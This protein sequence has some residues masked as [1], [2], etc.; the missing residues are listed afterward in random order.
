MKRIVWVILTLPVVLTLLW[1]Q[2][3]PDGFALD[4][5]WP[6]RSAMV[7]YSGVLVMAAMSVAL[8]LAARPALGERLCGGLDKCYRLHKWLGISALL[9]ATLHWL[10][11]QGPKWA[12]GL[13]W[14]ERPAR[15][16]AGQA[17]E[18]LA[19][20]LQGQ[21]GIAESLGEWA[22]YACVL[23]IVLA[24]IPRFPY[25]WFFRTHRLLA[26]AYL[27][28]VYHALI[29]AK[30]AYWATA[31]GVL[32]ALLLLAGSTAALLSLTRNIGRRRQVLG[33]IDTLQ[34]HPDNRVLA[35]RIRL[36]GAWPGHRAGQFAFVTFDRREG[37]HP[38]TISSA[39]LDDGCLEFAIKGLGDYTRTLPQTLRPGDPVT[40][41]GPY[42]HFD[43]S[44]R[45]AGQIWVAGGIGIAPFLARLRA[46]AGRTD[47]QPIDLFYCT[48]EPC[49]DFI[50]D[51]RGLAAA[52]Q[53]ELHLVIAPRGQRLTSQQ[54]R[55]DISDWQVRDIWFCGPSRFGRT[56]RRD[57]RAHGMATGDF[58]QELFEMR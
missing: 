55:A 4:R 40:V 13:G 44:S 35:V 31:L 11:A 33:R 32:G 27:L 38:F 43:F 6:L 8:I 17:G 24:L 42:G 16:G 52:A 7:Q 9:L 18:G 10:W 56:L 30:P 20:L 21:R 57:M 34:H 19:A 53:V 49:A 54:L 22:F 26:L 25:R 1:F 51:L 12:V 50:D 45:K 46:L 14:L 41:E 28:L 36:E 23:L 3:D 39:W 37:P 58:H 15:R 29:L 48:S 47:T 5:F 2:A